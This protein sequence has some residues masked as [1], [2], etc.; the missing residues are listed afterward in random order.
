MIISWRRFGA[1]HYFG[2]KRH[3]W[4]L[5]S[6]RMTSVGIRSCYAGIN[7]CCWS[8]ITRWAVIDYGE[9]AGRH[10]RSGFPV[11]SCCAA[12]PG[13]GDRADVC[14]RC[15]ACPITCSSEAYIIVSKDAPL[16]VVIFKGA[17]ILDPIAGVHIDDLG[18]AHGESL[19]LGLMNVATYDMAIALAD[20]RFSRCPFEIT[21]V[22]DRKLHAAFD[23]MGQGDTLV[24]QRHKYVIDHTIEQKQEV[25]PEAPELG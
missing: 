23:A 5:R 13:S 16:A 21:H 7:A 10:A 17:E 18:L 1:Q 3:A 15:P 20:S 19:D 14:C 6:V 25:V 4:V 22:F 11:E 2:R 24:A 12:M 8:A 9:D